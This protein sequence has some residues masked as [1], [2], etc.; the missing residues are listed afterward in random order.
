MTPTRSFL[1]LLSEVGPIGPGRGSLAGPPPPVAAPLAGSL[2]GSSLFVSGSSVFV[3][4]EP[5]RPPA[6]SRC[7]ARAS[8]RAPFRGDPPRTCCPPSYGTACSAAGSPRSAQQIPPFDQVSAPSAGRVQT[9]PHSGYVV[10]RTP[11]GEG[12]LRPGEAPFTRGVAPERSAQRGTSGAATG[13]GGP[14]APPTRIGS[15]PTR[16]LIQMRSRVT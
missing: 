2:R 15:S 5:C 8:L 9:R 6:P 16:M 4:G 13:G 11:Y 1:P 10:E 12:T 7:S 3:S 14:Q